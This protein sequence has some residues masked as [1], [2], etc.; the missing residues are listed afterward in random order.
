LHS[1]FFLVFS[2][3]AVSTLLNH[4]HVDAAKYLLFAN[5]NLMPYFFGEP[6]FEGMTL[7]FSI[8]NISIHM[9]LFFLL[10]G[11]LFSKRDVHV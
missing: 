7:P 5:T 9:L 11:Y 2:S 1:L 10:A 6:M 3:S 4:Y 8:T